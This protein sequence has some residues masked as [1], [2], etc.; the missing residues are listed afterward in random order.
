[1]SD[2]FPEPAPDFSDPLGLIRACHQRMLS[3]CELLEKLAA[4]LRHSGAD[5][6]ARKAARQAHRYFSTSAVFHHQDEEEDLFPR[7]GRSSMA[8][9]DTVH[10]LRQDHRALDEAWAAL[11]PMLEN[12]AHVGDTER[13]AQLVAQ[14]CDAYRE[15]I[16]IEEREFLDRAQHMLSSDELRKIGKAMQERRR[17]KTGGGDR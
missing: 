6:D 9:A 7:I 15:H 13:F 2:I 4:H 12:I 11:G 8:M 17:P 3:H 5:D 16:R 14:Y 1:M 10:R